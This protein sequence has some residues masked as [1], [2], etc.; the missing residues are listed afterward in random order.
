MPMVKG[1]LRS[2]WLSTFPLPPLTS[3]PT[4]PTTHT[5]FT[6]STSHQRFD[7]LQIHI[8]L[9]IRSG[10]RGEGEQSWGVS[11]VLT[12]MATFRVFSSH[13]AV[14]WHLHFW[15]HWTLNALTAIDSRIDLL[16]NYSSFRQL[17]WPKLANA[18]DNWQWN[19]NGRRRKGRRRSR[20]KQ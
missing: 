17:T 9:G 15:P 19:G 16:I 20:R 18:T 12:N 11:Q 8:K 2:N 13:C 14:L 5:M 4:P 7:I 10:S 6:H 3:F 1:C